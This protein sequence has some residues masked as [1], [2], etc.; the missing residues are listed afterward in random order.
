MGVSPSADIPP[1]HDADLFADVVVVGGGVIGLATAWRCAQR[2]FDVV[3]RDGRPGSGA[4]RYA[5]G[6]LA[7]VTEAHFGEEALL[8][9][10]IAA[11]AAYPAFAADVE[12]YAG[13]TIGYRTTGTLAIAFDADDR[14]VLTELHE[15][16]RSLGL[17][18]SLLTGRECRELEPALAPTVRGGLWVEGDH[19]VDNR[20]LVA[21]LLAACRRSG[22]RIVQ[23]PVARLEWDGDRVIGVDGARAA[24]TVLAA[25]AW[26]AHIEGLPEEMR[27]PVRPVKGQILR[28]AHDPSR[29]LL[30][31]VIRA[32][33]RGRPVYLVPRETGEIV[34]GGTVEELGFDQR[35]TVEAVA[36]LL[37]DARQLVPGLVDAD[38]VEASAGLR[39]GS[40]DNAPIVGKIGP[41][42]LVV[43]TGHYR[44][45]ILL[46]PVTADSVAEL[47]SSGQLPEIMR[48]FD[49]R[50]FVGA[51]VDAHSRPL[52]GEP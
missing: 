40:P 18:S 50:R 16:H 38:F 33:V 32:F 15:Y 9:L 42:G 35:V 28:L 1:S 29:P 25:G 49:A 8:R 52:A 10:N 21:A 27:P 19:Q 44:N 3:L 45:G 46:T 51:V 23:R 37:A 13:Q 22:V 41:E 39:P 24:W 20:R 47:L 4:S 34:L 6:M 17:A 14:A 36:D 12:E 2:G 48:P 11:A 43:A 30:G 5:A 7:P 31:H 26:S